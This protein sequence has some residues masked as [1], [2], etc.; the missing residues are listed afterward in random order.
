[1]KIKSDT[2][3]K[4]VIGKT[5]NLKNFIALFTRINNQDVNHY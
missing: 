1:M 2:D 4:L 5:F 3:D